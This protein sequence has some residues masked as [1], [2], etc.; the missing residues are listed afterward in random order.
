MMGAFSIISLL[1]AAIGIY[2]IMA[3]SVS[4]R[5][6]EIGIRLA[7]GAPAWRIL[8]MVLSDAGRFVV[9]G[10]VAG[11]AGAFGVSQFLSSLLFET[12]SKDPLSFL[13][14]PTILLIVALVAAYFPARRAARMDPMIALRIE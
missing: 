1:L 13:I 8:M 7:V 10:L 2:G 14:A 3:Y 9:P 11:L 6:R 5:T 12:G 4:E